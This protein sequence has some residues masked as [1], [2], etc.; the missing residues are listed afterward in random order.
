[1]SRLLYHLDRM[2]LA[3]TPAVRWIDG[4][5]LVI[6]AM[7][8]FGFVP[9]RFLTTGI[10]LVLF[11]SFIWLRR[12]W[13]SRDYVQF[14]EL[15]TP[16]VAPKPLA[17][18][19]SVP[20]HASGYFTVEEKSE[21]FTWLQGYFR[22]F[23]T[24]EHAVICLV[25]PKRF[26]LAEWP[27]KDVGMWYVFF[28]PKSVRSVS[29]GMVS[30]G[31]TTHTCLAIEHE[32][33]IPKR[34]RFSRERTVQETVLLASPTEEDTLRILADLL[35]DREAKDEEDIAPKRPNPRPDPTHN[36]Q[37]KIPMGETRR[38]D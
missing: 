16:S 20:I 6:G 19:D 23:A 3:G 8:G 1:M 18:K 26:L 34:G 14:R 12:L 10:C 7:A 35:H 32:I 15:A 25:Q 9:G 27:E 36:G 28:F 4:L 13:R 11:V 30:Y 2:M 37:V 17:P 33:L 31:S 24:R 5:L 38:L 29:Y 21:R 22:T